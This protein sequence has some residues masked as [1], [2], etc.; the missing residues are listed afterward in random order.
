MQDTVNVLDPA[1]GWCLRRPFDA[2]QDVDGAT[3]RSG[4]PA[5]C[6]SARRPSLPLFRCAPAA[7]VA[8]LKTLKALGLLVPKRL[9][10]HSD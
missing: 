8:N 7:N 6:L 2:D 10:L 5:H 4:P 1:P 3:L 9:L